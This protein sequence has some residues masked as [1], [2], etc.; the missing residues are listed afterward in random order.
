MIMMKNELFEAY[1][2]LRDSGATLECI[3][4]FIKMP[5]GEVECI[6][7]PEVDRKLVY[8]DG[9][10]DDELKLKSNPEIQIEDFVFSTENDEFD[11]GGALE[12]LKAGHK[13]ARRG[14]NG[15]QMCVYLTEGSEVPYKDMKHAVQSALECV[16]RD[17]ADEKAH[18]VINPHLDMVSARGDIIVG[19]SASQTDMLAEDWYLVE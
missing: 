2:S 7:N 11:F 5:K 4:L 17:P 9:A 8:I 18:I 6:V 14:W 3:T 13:V 15:K 12:L 16:E 1:K 19:W 10:Y